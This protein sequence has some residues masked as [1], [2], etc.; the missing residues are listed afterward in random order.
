[1][2]GSAVTSKRTIVGSSICSGRRLRI[3]ATFSRTSAAATCGS[4]SSRN[5]RPTRENDSVELETTRFTPLIPATASSMGLVTSVSTSSGD[6]PGYTTLTLTNGKLTSGNRSIPSLRQRHDA[7]HHE[8]HDDHRGEDGR[9]IEMS[10]IH[11]LVPRAWC[12]VLRAWFVQRAW[13][14]AW[15]GGTGYRNTAFT[16]VPTATSCRASDTITSP[17]LQSLGNL[18]DAPV[19][20]SFDHGNLPSPCRLRL[21]TPPVCPRSS[22]PPR[23]EPPEPARRVRAGRTA[24]PYMPD[25]SVTARIGDAHFDP[26]VAVSRSRLLARRRHASLEVSRPRVPV[27]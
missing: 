5:S 17:G 7:E 8:A 26:E 21:R 3:A 25:S 20:H 12:L 9:R 1:M 2:I 24:A 15:F 19:A 23:A 13:C 10:E 4:T 22:S 6:A 27:R 14:P 16:F 11:I 18:H